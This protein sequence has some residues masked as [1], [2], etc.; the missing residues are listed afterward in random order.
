MLCYQ[1]SGFSMEVFVCAKKHTTAL[2]W[3]FCCAIALVRPIPWSTGV[4]GNEIWSGAARNN[5]ASLILTCV[6]RRWT[7]SH[8]A[9]GANCSYCRPG[10]TNLHAPAP[11]LWGAG[12]MHLLDPL[13][14][15][16]EPP[17][18]SLA[19]GPPLWGDG[20]DA[21]MDDE[22]QTEPGWDIAAHPVP[23]YEVD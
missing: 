17:H 16:S 6:V 19:R 1:Y 11:L 3:R 10:R 5:T 12:I 18:I 15:D 9:T 13:G 4:K 22:V 7:R 14:A 8:S 20:G 21:E 23:D 2:G